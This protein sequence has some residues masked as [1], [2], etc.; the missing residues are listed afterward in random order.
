MKAAAPQLSRELLD[1][2]VMVEALHWG[3][4]QYRDTQAT[5]FSES[6]VDGFQCITN[7]EILKQVKM[8]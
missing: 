1:F 3:C 7:A 5:S 2:L 8:L 6:D 4:S